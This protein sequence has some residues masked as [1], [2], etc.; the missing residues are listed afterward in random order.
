MSPRNIGA[1]IRARL[2]NLAKTQ[3]TDFNLVLTQF[4]LERLLYRLGMSP[5]AARFLLKGALLFNLWY[6]LPRRPTR[7]ADLLGFGSSNISE[8]IQAFK[9]ICAIECDDGIVFLPETVNAEEIRKEAGYPGVRVTLR[10]ELDGARCSVQVDIGFGDAVTPAPET[11]SYPVLLSNLPA[12]TV[13]AYPRYSVVAEKFQ[14]IVLFSI[15]NSRMKDYF[16]LWTIAEHSE[17]DGRLLARAMLETFTRRETPLPDNTPLG[18]GDD[19]AADDLKQ[20]QWRAFLNKSRL[21]APDLATLVA[22]LRTF[23]LPPTDAARSGTD[24][25]KKWNPKGPWTHVAKET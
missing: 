23:L 11:T 4:G 8:L 24:F 2:L 25:K 17:L 12:P 9:N 1:S 19:F 13:R 7:D 20:R 22:Y 3:G 14:A 6:D 15:A 10:G 21:A 5:H 16:D 18:L